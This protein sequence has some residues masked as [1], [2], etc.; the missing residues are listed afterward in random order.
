MSWLLLA[1]L[2]ST[3]RID[4][5]L[6]ECA[7]PVARFELPRPG[8]H[9]HALADGLVLEAS[10][11]RLVLSHCFIE[12]HEVRTVRA[13]LEPLTEVE[14]AEGATVR[15]GQRVGRGAR[16][17]VLVNGEPAARFVA[18]RQR[19]L[20]PAAV[21]VLVVVDVDGHR[22]VR[23]E[24]GQPTHEWE[25]ARGQGDGV[26]EVRGDLKT[27]RGLYDVVGKSLGPFGG[28]YADY[29]GGVWLK[30]NYPNAF[31]AARGLDAGVISAPSAQAISSAWRARALTPQGT[32]LGGGIG[33][34]GWIADWSGDAGWGLSWGCLVLHPEEARGFYDV[35]P[36]GA[37]VVLL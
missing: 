17:K 3:P 15:Q 26:K 20:V 30:V 33:F 36:V 25:L 37:Q 12:N 23:L 34:H 8:P 10:A 16:A 4:A 31:D 35:V 14:V 24:R 5:F 21:P 32:K 29:Y 7:A 28:A 6:T 2:A 27:P 9:V 13:V 11:T 22:A 19:L 1:A 18:A